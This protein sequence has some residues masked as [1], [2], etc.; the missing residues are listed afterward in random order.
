MGA[1]A[2]LIAYFLDVATNLN[3][4][5]HTPNSPRFFRT[6]IDEFLSEF[7]IVGKSTCLLLES[8]DYSLA[9]GSPDNIIKTRDIAFMVV[10][11]CDKADDFNAIAAIYDA[12]EAICDEII[13]KINYDTYERKED[14][15]QQVNITG[16]QV[17]PV[18]N[19]VE[20]NYGQRVVISMQLY[21]DLTPN[22]DNWKPGYLILD[23]HYVGDN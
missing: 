1:N 6:E 18:V 22:P 8:S 5:G 2:D 17:Q 10:Q 11:H 9:N 23:P 3:A 19:F 7:N 16:I 4:I 21:H 20:Y 13:A 14:A 12:T 15:F